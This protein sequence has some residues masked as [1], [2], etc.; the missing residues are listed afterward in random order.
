[1]KKIA[2]ADRSDSSLWALK[3][4]IMIIE[5]KKK[6]AIYLGYHGDL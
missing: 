4:L 6:G 2:L 3:A 1:M 5:M